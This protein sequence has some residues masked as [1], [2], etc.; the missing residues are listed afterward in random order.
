MLAACCAIYLDVVG[1]RSSAVAK[2]RKAPQIG[3]RASSLV[4]GWRMASM[5]STWTPSSTKA[6]LLVSFLAEAASMQAAML[7]TAQPAVEEH[8][9]DMRRRSRLYPHV[10]LHSAL[11]CQ[12]LEMRLQSCAC[13]ACPALSTPCGTSH[14]CRSQKGPFA[15]ASI[16]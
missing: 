1:L 13:L 3:L 14:S 15:R 10:A 12:T 11:L 8:S 2:L 4:P 16:S 6:H 9:Q 5:S 7:P